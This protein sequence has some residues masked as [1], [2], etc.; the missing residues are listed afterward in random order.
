MEDDNNKMN[1]SNPTDSSSQKRKRNSN[2]C[3]GQSNKRSSVYPRSSENTNTPQQTD[4]RS[5][6]L[7]LKRVFSRVLGDVT[8]TV[9]NTPSE[10]QSGVSNHI[11]SVHRLSESS[12]GKNI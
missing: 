5:G 7:P 11:E 4:K 8:N 2:D 6:L 3:S 1:G 10:P 9:N 12:R